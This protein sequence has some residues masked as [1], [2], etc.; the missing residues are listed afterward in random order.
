[1]SNFNLKALT[2]P[3]KSESGLKHA[4]LQSL[5]N[6]GKAQIN[7]E[8]ESGQD[9]QGWWGTEFKPDISCRDWTLARA[10]NTNDTLIKSKRF[11]E[12]SLQWLIDNN[13]AKTIDVTTSF[14]QMKLVRTIDITL[15]DNTKYQVKA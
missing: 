4:V 3:L 12:Q 1:V 5:L 6:F 2:E 8:I 10:K 14:E 15:I 7:D 13:T 9:K 11:T